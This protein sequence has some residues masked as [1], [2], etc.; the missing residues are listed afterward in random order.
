M[1][2][3]TT[4]W[5]WRLSIMIH[6][7]RLTISFSFSLTQRCKSILLAAESPRPYVLN[8]GMFHVVARLSGVPAAVIGHRPVTF[9]RQFAPTDFRPT[10]GVAHL[11][12]PGAKSLAVL[13]NCTVGHFLGDINHCVDLLRRA[14]HTT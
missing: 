6:T 10:R 12:S 13:L 4:S 9:E 2:P 3:E 11:V 14:V 5:Q 8:F 1:S 7:R